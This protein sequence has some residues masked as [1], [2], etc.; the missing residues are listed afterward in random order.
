MSD[1]P[2][3]S[4]VPPARTCTACGCTLAPTD[5]YH[6]FRL[7]IEAEQDLSALW[8]TGA[9]VHDLLARMREERTWER[10]EDDVHWETAGELCGACRAR[11]RALAEEFGIR[12][13]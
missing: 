12:P 4:R 11:L 1:A 13:A 6:R 7:V 8:D 10:Y 2:S 9:S 5:V 3:P